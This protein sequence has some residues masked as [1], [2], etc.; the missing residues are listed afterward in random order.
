MS[1][2]AKIIPAQVESVDSGTLANAA[3]M[4]N[5]ISSSTM[6]ATIVVTTSPNTIGVNASRPRLVVARSA[7]RSRARGKPSTCSTV[8]LWRGAPCKLACSSCKA[9]MTAAVSSEDAINIAADGSFRE[10][11]RISSMSE[12]TA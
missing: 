7:P 11:S 4:G 10:L 6:L 3:G 1:Y 2:N 5:A 8:E 12:R 9:E